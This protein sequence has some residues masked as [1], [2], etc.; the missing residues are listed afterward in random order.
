MAFVRRQAGRR[1]FSYWR[2][3]AGGEKHEFW[4]VATLALSLLNTGIH[5]FAAADCLERKCLHYI[6]VVGPDVDSVNLKE[7]A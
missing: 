6:P 7:R 2:S 4:F 5:N 1:L 3:N